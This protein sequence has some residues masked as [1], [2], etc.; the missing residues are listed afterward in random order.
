MPRSMFGRS[1]LILLFPVVLLQL[2]VGLVFIQRHFEKVT[3]QMARPV[4]VELNYIAELA[5]SAR[6]PEAANTLLATFS[7][8]FSMQFKV[9]P[10]EVLIPEFRRYFYDVSGRALIGSLIEDVTRPISVNL[11]QNGR[12][13]RVRMQTN[14]GIVSVVFSRSRVS[15]SNP[16]QLLV[17]MIVA[18]ILLTVVSV[19]FLRNQVRPIRD[20]ARVSEA[21]GKGRIEHLRPSGA[22]EVRRATA[23]F[24]AMRERIEHQIDQRTQMLSGV[25]HDLRTPLTR[26]KLSLAMMEQNDEIKHLSQ[27]VEDM[28]RMLDG[29][30]DFARQDTLEETEATDPAIMLE[31]IAAD[32]KR[33]G[34]MIEVLFKNETPDHPTI[35]LH[36]LSISRAVSNLVSNANRFGDKVQITG[37]LTETLLTIIVEDNGPGIAEK[38]RE[39]A[40]KPFARLDQSRNQNESGVGL[41]LSIVVDVARSHGGTLELSKSETLGGLKAIL[42][43]P[44]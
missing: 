19:L 7:R 43:I 33:S 15:A 36:P 1:L 26:M 14:K 34:H 21:F 16:H 41:G 28:G 40:M 27:D 20:L 8:P 17:L 32:S 5:D 42:S 18:S 10:D 38:D 23:S 4:A 2:V 12:N 37:H 30:L 39:E 11:T 9:I 35:T 6:T 25:S 24:L 29:F 31:K 13:V 22:I 44:R 3:T